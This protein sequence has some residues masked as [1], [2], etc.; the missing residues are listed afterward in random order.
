M[1]SKVVIGI[2]VIVVILLGAIALKMFFPNVS[3]DTG[4]TTNTKTGEGDLAMKDDANDPVKHMVLVFDDSGSMAEKV[5]SGE[6]RINVA[7]TAAS[8][9]IAGLTENVRLSVVVYG[10]KGDNSQA[11]KNISCAGIEEVFPLGPVNVSVAQGYI[12]N[13]M[14]TGWTP[15]ADSLTKAHDILKR[16][17]GDDNTVVL[18]SDGEETCG[19]NPIQVAKMLCEMGIKTQVIGLGVGGMVEAQ[20][21]DIAENG[22]GKYYDTDSNTEIQNAFMEI[23]G[24]SIDRSEFNASVDIMG[25]VNSSGDNGSAN[26]NG[27]DASINAADGRS[28]ETNPDGSYRL[29][30]ADGVE[31]DVPSGYD[32]Y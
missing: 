22:C 18:L 26:I 32:G 31:I 19:G 11:K 28:V 12:N 2:G 10:H 14:P 9:F 4:V 24:N 17:G 7:K 23:G 5:P 21:S 29:R 25:N 3:L 1:N 30:N 13:L 6:S 20:L 8:K 27:S 15:I 16:A